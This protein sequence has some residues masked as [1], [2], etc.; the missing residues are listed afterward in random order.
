MKA[1][2]R[3]IA[4]KIVELEKKCNEGINVVENMNSIEDII[5]SLTADELIEID[6]YITEKHLLT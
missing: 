6:N 3:K 5:G 2:L 4:Q 1:K